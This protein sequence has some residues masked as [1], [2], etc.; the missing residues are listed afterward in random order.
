VD[1]I[2]GSHEPERNPTWFSPD[3]ARKILGKGREVKYAREM[4]AV[5]DRALDHV[6]SAKAATA[7]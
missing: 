3:D 1:L 4:Q 5:I 6:G 2:D 7:Q